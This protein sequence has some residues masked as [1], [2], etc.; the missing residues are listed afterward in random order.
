MALFCLVLFSLSEAL[1]IFVQAFGL[2]HALVQLWKGASFPDVLSYLAL[3]SCAF[4]AVRIVSNMREAFISSYATKCTDAMRERLLFSIFRT[5]APAIQQFGTGS[6]G[7]LVLDGIDK[8]RTYLEL[9]LPKLVS[10]IVVPLMLAIMIAFADWV[11][12]VVVIILL[13][14]MVLLMILIGKTTA[15]RGREQ[16]ASFKV[17]S[18]HFIDSVRGVSTLSTFEVSKTYA[19]RVFTVSERFRESTMRTLRTAT[20]SGSVLDLFATLAIAAVSIMLGLRLIDGSLA[21]LPALFVLILTPEYFRPIR[22]FASDYHASLDGA[23]SLR[24]INEIF[25]ATKNLPPHCAIPTWNKQSTLHI[26]DLSKHY[27]DVV[28]LK[29]ISLECKGSQIIGLIGVSGSGKSTLL[30]I[31]SGLEDPTSGSIVLDDKCTLDTFRHIGWQDQIAYIPQDPYIFALSLRENLTFYEPNATPEQ[32]EHAIE[33]VGLKSLVASLPQGLDTLIGEGGR[34]LSG[35][36]AQ[37]IALARVVLDTK[38]KIMLFDEPTAHLDIETEYELKQAMLEVMKDK[39]VI[40]ATHRLHWID[41]FDRV[42]V[43]DEGTIVEEGTPDEL[44]DLGEHFI[45]LVSALRGGDV[46]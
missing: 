37:R 19:Q 22:E 38:R 34:G 7:A 41:S 31:L 35:G 25:E 32:I 42:L 29:S 16:H 14:S 26:N 27:G 1:C 2:S 20:L 9:V 36:Q 17:M 45:Q 28:A 43:L 21:L 8:V 13:P 46:A 15:D 33:V 40:F 3:F 30:R 11:S 4:V 23:N 18:N 12:G 5:G 24:S 10:M 6:T 44:R 39:L